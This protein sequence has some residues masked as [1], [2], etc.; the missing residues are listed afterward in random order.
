MAVINQNHQHY[1]PDCLEHA[2]HP[3]HESNLLLDH[4]HAVPLGRSLLR[5]FVLLGLLLFEDGLHLL[6]IQAVSILNLSRPALL[7]Q[8]LHHIA[9][10]FHEEG[11]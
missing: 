8:V 9:D 1:I 11:D 7:H 6:P 4:L 10:L 2:A 5:L 3:A